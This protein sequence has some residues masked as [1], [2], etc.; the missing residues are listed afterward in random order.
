MDAI[1]KAGEQFL[2]TLMAYPR[3]WRFI[4][5]YKLW[6]GLWQY[7]WVF[8]FLLVVAI[9]SIGALYGEI[10]DWLRSHQQTNAAAFFIGGDSLVMNLG[11][12]T[13]SSLTNGA[14]KWVV[15]I[16]FE[17]VVYHFMRGTLFVVLGKEMPGANSFH[18]FLRAQKRM[19]FV[20]VTAFVL[21]IVLVNVGTGI[22]FGILSPLSWLKQPLALLIKA[23]LVG[24]AIVDNY[25]EQFKLSVEQSLR[26][27]RMNYIGVALG[28]GLPLYLMLKI[29]LLGSVAG[30]ILASVT[31]AIVMKEVADLH[32]VGYQPSEN[33]RQ[34]IAKRAAK[35]AAKR[36]RK[37]QQAATEPT[38]GDR[39]H[40]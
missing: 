39:Y 36:S 25:N 6:R 16:L 29:P 15:L 32:T 23:S 21:E 24:F 14:G 20:S 26:Y 13:F 34:K 3:A 31:A 40:L 4:G 10:N 17:V 22:L 19:I 5:H 11:K 1:R 2:Y 37:G 33:E 30:P 9:L 27:T 8:R 38:A 7:R 35:R 28:V 12:H 18:P